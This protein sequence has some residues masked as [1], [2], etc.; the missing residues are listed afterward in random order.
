MVFEVGILTNGL[1]EKTLLAVAEF[2]M[3]WLVFQID[4]LIFSGELLLLVKVSVMYAQRFG[5]AVCFN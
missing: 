3:V 1:Q 4:P 2:L 5:F